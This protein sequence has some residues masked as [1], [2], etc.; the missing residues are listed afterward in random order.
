MT[1]IK[2][3]E[4]ALKLYDTRCALV[5]HFSK[6]TFGQVRQDVDDAFEFLSKRCKKGDGVAALTLSCSQAIVLEWATYKLGCTWIG[7]PWRERK[8]ENIVSIL[9]ACRPK[10][11]FLDRAALPAPDLQILLKS[12][13]LRLRKNR[14]FRHLEY[15]VLPENLQRRRVSFKIGDE[16]IVRIRFTSGVS[17]EPKGIIYTQKTQE[18]ILNNL[19]EQ[20]SS[21]EN[22]VTSENEVMIH[23]APINWASGSLIAPVLCNG[24]CNVLRPKWMIEDFVEAV[25]REQC[26]LTFLAPRMLSQLV[27][28]SERHGS[29]WARTLRRVL[30][31]GGPTPVSTMRSARRLFRKIRFYTTL[32]MTEASFPITWHEVDKSD[33]ENNNR[34]YIPLGNLTRFYEKSRIDNSKSKQNGRGELLVKGNAVAAGKWTW[35]DKTGEP[36]KAPIPDK[37]TR[38]IRSGDIVECK[39]GLLHY[40]C[41]KD[42]SCV[43]LNTYLAV[44]AVEALLR[45]AEGVIEARIDRIVRKGKLTRVDVTIQTTSADVDE[46]KVRSFFERKAP[47]ANLRQIEIGTI[48][49]G[50]V[51]KTQT[52]KIIHGKSLCSMLRT[53]LDHSCYWKDFVFGKTSATEFDF[54]QI[55]SS[56]LYFYVGA[57]LSMSSGLAG[58]GEMAS[59]LWSYLKDYEKK[60]SLRTCPCDDGK[61]NAQFLDEFVTEP[62]NPENSSSKRIL[63][64]ESKDPRSKGRTIALNLI[65]RLRAPRTILDMEERE[66]PFRR[67]KWDRTRCGKEPNAE[68]L[69]LQTLIWRTHCH[70]VLTSNY[71]N[72]LEHAYAIFNHGAALRSYRYNADFLRHIMTNPKFVLKL[73]GDINDIGKMQLSPERAW[74]DDKLFAPYRR[75]LK[76]TYIEAVQE[77]HMIYLGM[78]FRDETIIR[79]H[80]AWRKRKQASTNLR[81]ALIPRWELRR[82]KNDLGTRQEL[83]DDVLFLTYGSDDPD[84]VVR[85]Y[86][87]REFLSQIVEARSSYKRKQNVC[88]EATAIHRR[89]FLSLRWPRLTTGTS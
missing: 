36:L 61:D 40:V 27:A 59:M 37:F 44:D 4:E 50:P 82:I 2:S 30:L 78:G 34:P 33:V 17:G 12:A 85:D 9:K 38:A 80:K 55:K 64:H 52:G 18:E 10:I 5:D 43:K 70:G 53:G 11:F 31:A 45:D 51:E 68:D 65:L 21:S 74:T 57:G 60:R 13:D 20:L 69:V 86:S 54:S 67:V 7:I 15:F 16:R 24:G 75:D 35:L 19:R 84:P 66:R 76:N 83:F 29:E 3:V 8:P 1:F 22:E 72:L 28:Y 56:H 71:D 6:R 48:R 26:T 88:P 58:W 77:G 42:Q 46:K 23:G 81:L 63:E 41:R 49:S 87:V 14:K 32:G 62:E 89:M 79:L 47:E 73:H 25:S 39:G